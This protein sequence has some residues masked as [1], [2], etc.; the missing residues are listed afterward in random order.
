MHRRPEFEPCT[1]KRLLEEIFQD[2]RAS[3]WKNL[4]NHLEKRKKRRY[5]SIS[6]EITEKNIRNDMDV[7][8]DK[9]SNDDVTLETNFDAAADKLKNVEPSTSEGKNSQY[10]ATLQESCAT[11][12]SKFIDWSESKL[13]DYA[14]MKNVAMVP[15]VERY[16][17]D[18]FARESENTC[19]NN[20]E[21]RS[22]Y[23]FETHLEIGRD[24]EHS[25]QRLANFEMRNEKPSE[26]T[27][28][29][30]LAE[31]FLVSILQEDDVFMKNSQQ[32][33]NEKVVDFEM[34]A[35][36]E[37]G[38]ASKGSAEAE[39]KENEN[40]AKVADTFEEFSFCQPTDKDDDA[41]TRKDDY[42][43]ERFGIDPKSEANCTEEKSAFHWSKSAIS[44]SKDGE[45]DVGSSPKK[46]ST[47]ND[48]RTESTIFFSRS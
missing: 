2:I 11:C 28:S 12:S 29:R 40:P 13:T 21:V 5:D 24:D 41:R 27:V 16:A 25:Q 33:P 18:A 42:F 43:D 8:F 47:R 19:P 48:R 10:D 30:S 1:V 45:E 37:T 46:N 32:L 4:K 15:G 44:R 38:R 23:K 22:S 6:I 17:E 35:S 20:N 34:D 3:F 36:E 31:K 26:T 9:T 7:Y 14:M 39:Q